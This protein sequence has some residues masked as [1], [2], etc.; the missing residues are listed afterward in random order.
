MN[1]KEIKGCTI[2]NKDFTNK[3]LQDAIWALKKSFNIE[4]KKKKIKILLTNEQWSDIVV[5]ATIFE[6]DEARKKFLEERALENGP[7]MLY[8]CQVI[9]INADKFYIFGED[10]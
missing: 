3:V 6:E 4:N 2:G 10:V 8:G 5:G 9:S 1:V 7:V